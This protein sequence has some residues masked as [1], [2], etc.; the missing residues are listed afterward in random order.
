MFIRKDFNEV[1]MNILI[2]NDDGIEGEGL[3]ALAGALAGKHHVTVVAPESERSAA[4]HSY[5]F[6]HPLGLKKVNKP[7]FEGTEAYITNGTPCDCVIL[8]LQIVTK[9]NV[10]L[11]L[12]GINVGSNLGTDTIASGT[13]QAAM[14]GCMRGYPAL[15]VSQ[16]IQKLVSFGRHSNYFSH[17][18]AVTAGL[19]ENLDYKQ[20]HN[21]MLSINFPYADKSEIKGVK[22]CPLGISK[23]N[24]SYKP[25]KDFVGR[26]H[27]W[28]DVERIPNDYNQQNGTD[29]KWIDERYITITPL[30]PNLTELNRMSAVQ[31][32]V[33]L[34]W[35]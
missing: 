12:S 31:D 29:V 1:L 17:A 23:N 15:A 19:L 11:I 32:M 7:G 30:Y 14:E 6:N 16:E 27:Y 34:H 8:G 2:V 10:D 21:Y 9:G 28:I 24:F 35:K 3:I 18:A 25:Q 13:V 4:G 5:T 33:D 22:V 20:I 26:E